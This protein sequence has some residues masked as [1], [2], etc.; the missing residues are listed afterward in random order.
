MKQRV[1]I[2]RTLANDPAIMLMDEP[3]GA[4]G[5][6]TREALQDQLLEIWETTRKT[7]LFVTHSIQEAVVLSD[8]IA[9]LEAHPGRLVDVIH[10][11]L[12]RPRERTD[13]QVVELANHI[14]GRRYLS[15][16]AH[17]LG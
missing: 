11:H 8:A 17:A 1:A 10:N 13:A 9:L 16:A 4:L 7:V 12:S 14:Y 5:A 15:D 2:A 3:F 6:Q